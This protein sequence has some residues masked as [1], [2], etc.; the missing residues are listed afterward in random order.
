MLGLELLGSCVGEQFAHAATSDVP[1]PD[2]FA[3]QS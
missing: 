2:S 1:S 3:Q